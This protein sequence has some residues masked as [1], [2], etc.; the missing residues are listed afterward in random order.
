VSVIYFEAT[1]DSKKRLEVPKKF[2]RWFNE[3]VIVQLDEANNVLHIVKDSKG[4]ELDGRRRLALGMFENTLVEV[5]QV[6]GG[7]RVRPKPR[8]Y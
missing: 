7:L 1:I 6:E 4:V 3:P 8:R 2:K 5:R